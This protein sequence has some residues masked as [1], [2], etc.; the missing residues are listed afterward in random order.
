MIFCTL[1][2][3]FVF[4][5]FIASTF[6]KQGFGPGQ[7]EWGY[8]EVRPKA[9][10]FWWLY[11]TTANVSSKYE[12]RPL[13][14]WLQGGPGGS[15]TGIGNFREIGP[16]DANLNPRNHT[17]TKD[18]N[19]LFIDNP[20]G[21]GFSYVESL[22]LLVTT[23]AQ[24][25]SDLVQCIKGFFN[26]VT[27]FSKTP[28]YILAESYGGKMG[29]EFANLWY[30]EQLNGGIKSN[31]KG[32]GLI[33][34][35]ISAIDNYS[36]FASYLLHMGFVDNNGYRIVDEIAKKL[37][38]AGE[39]GDWNEVI[40]FTQKIE[41]LIVNITNNMDWYNI[42]KKVE[43]ASVNST[44]ELV[45]LMND[46]VKKAL[47]LENRW[48]V[49]SL[50]VFLSLLEDNMKPVIHQVENLLNESTLKVYVLTGQL[51]FI[52]NTPGTL[53]WIDKMRWRHAVEWSKAPMVPLVIN[54]VI[55]G[56]SKSYD[57]F[58]LFWVNRSGH[59]IPVDNPIAMKSILQDL[60][61]CC[62]K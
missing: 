13:V 41:N 16:L 28:T 2:Y 5:F 42:L 24:I 51:D 29:V 27:I 38:A 54:N 30:K 23:N 37:E 26:N 56:Y 9:H 17:W 4:S 25:A 47:S 60:I 46:K 40:H 6:A 59:M 55:E 36:F 11:Y 8:V 21:T 49:Q 39:A 10:M 20:V 33:D 61:K 35:S 31:L 14:I 57:R 34:S 58:K 19:V 62:F 50:Y 32:V 43:T 22:D 48:G 12:T 53:Q 44:D 18:Y 45:G 52:I 3:I 7:Q 1:R 15:S